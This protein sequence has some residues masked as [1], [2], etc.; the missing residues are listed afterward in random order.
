MWILPRGTTKDDGVRDALTSSWRELG[1]TAARATSVT[2]QLLRDTVD[3]GRGMH[4]PPVRQEPGPLLVFLVS[5]STDGIHRQQSTLPPAAYRSRR[6]EEKQAQEHLSA[7]RI[8]VRFPFPAPSFCSCGLRHGV[9][10][11]DLKTESPITECLLRRYRVKMPAGKVERIIVITQEEL[12][13][14]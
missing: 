8:Q 4:G 10:S 7:P 1:L 12:M 6:E 2:C 5:G 11:H 13:M 3:V 9:S 14:F